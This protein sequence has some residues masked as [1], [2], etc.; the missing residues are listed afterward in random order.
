MLETNHLADVQRLELSASEAAC[1]DEAS[2]QAYRRLAI[3]V[4]ARA[5]LD[6]NGPGGSASDRE[7]ARVFLAGSSMLFHWCRVASLDPSWVVERVERLDH[8]VSAT[9][10][11]AGPS[12]R[13]HPPAAP[14]GSDPAARWAARHIAR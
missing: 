2:T 11:A 12:P 14:R 10:A 4:L 5:L 1:R 3:R 13:P 9:N 7:S 8:P 6:A